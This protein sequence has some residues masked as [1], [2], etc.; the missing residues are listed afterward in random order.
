MSGVALVGEVAYLSDFRMHV[1]SDA[2]IPVLSTQEKHSY[3]GSR[4]PDQ[5]LLLKPCYTEPEM[6]V[7]LTSINRRMVKAFWL[8]HTSAVF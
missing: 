4:R 5:G 3:M 1:P 2:E 8:V 7:T 6:G